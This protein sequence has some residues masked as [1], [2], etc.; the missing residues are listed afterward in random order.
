MNNCGE[1]HS[2]DPLPSRL[3]Q[4]S[5]ESFGVKLLRI[6]F[7]YY[8]YLIAIFSLHVFQSM[9]MP[10]MTAA[11]KVPL[12]FLPKSAPKGGKG[13]LR[14]VEVF[15]VEEETNS[16]QTEVRANDIEED[17][18]LTNTTYYN[19]KWVSGKNETS[20][21]PQQ[22]NPPDGY[23]FASEWKIDVSNQTSL[24]SQGWIE[25]IEVPQITGG[26]GKR[27]RRRRWVR[28][29]QPVSSS[30]AT[31]L[32]ALQKSSP[33]FANSTEIS[34][35]SSNASIPSHRRKKKKKTRLTR[36]VQAIE[37]E[38]RFK[39]FGWT[40]VKSVL[41][42]ESCGAGLK[43]PLSSNFDVIERCPYIP[44]ISSVR[45]FFTTIVRQ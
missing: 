35:I 24:D 17:F 40:I 6:K 9:S 22:I 12:S 29:I 27:K 11:S 32:Q 44:I 19:K 41:L 25:Y 8:Y 10:E 43:I 42:K 36:L 2:E 37:N 18:I 20:R 38:F 5:G 1:L 14:F 4:P 28:S 30:D 33:D 13:M 16:T 34:A 23:S 15:E 26:S 7:G 45:L 21:P 39:G 31:S 3:L